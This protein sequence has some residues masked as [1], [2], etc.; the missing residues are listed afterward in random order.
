MA[1]PRHIANRY[2]L[3]SLLA[4][5]PFVLVWRARDTMLRRDVTVTLYRLRASN[6]PVVAPPARTQ[7]WHTLRTYA[8]LGANPR[9]APVLDAGVYRGQPYIVSPLMAGPT[10]RDRQRSLPE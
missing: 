2:R 5:G 9:L 7:F 10:L 1:V 3:S 8:G 6:L 4:D